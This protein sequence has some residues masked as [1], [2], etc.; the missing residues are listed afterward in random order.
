MAGQSQ[1]EASEVELHSSST[2]CWIVV[3]GEVW[4]VTEFLVDH[5][6]GANGKFLS[7]NL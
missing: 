5:P 6:G 4:D 2:D 1:V 3:N 7:Q